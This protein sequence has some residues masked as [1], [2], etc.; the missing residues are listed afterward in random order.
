MN[1]TR[2][3]LAVLYG[4]HHS[5]IS[6]WIQEFKKQEALHDGHKERE[7]SRAFGDDQIAWIRMLFIDHPSLYLDEAQALFVKKFGVQISLSSISRIL[8][9]IGFSRKVMEKRAIQIK[10]NDIDFYCA[11]LQSL[12]WDIFNIVFLDKVSFDNRDMFRE[13]GY[14][15][16]GKKIVDCDNHTRKARVSA[17]CFLGYQGLLDTF[18]VDGTFTRLNFFESCKAFALSGKVRQYPGKNSI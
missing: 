10:S 7:T 8:A 13:K 11:E 5:T 4:K 2:S 9:K 12:A 1:K 18:V 3:A 16:I 14:G 15:P 17:L 6:N